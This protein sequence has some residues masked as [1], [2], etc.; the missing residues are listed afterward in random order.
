M[1]NKLTNIMCR[2]QHLTVII[3]LF[4]L[5]LA[6]FADVL[7][8]SKEIVLSKDGTDIY[9]QF[10]YWRS[11]GF[12]ELRKGNLALWNPYIFSGMPFLGGFQSAL[13]YPLN[14]LYLILPIIKAINYSIA[15][16]IFLAGVFMYLWTNHRKL[17]PFA[18]FISSVILMF[19][20][21]H[22]MHI[23]PGHL[24]NLCTMIWI[25]LLFLAIDGLYEKPSLG[26]IL[27][28]IFSITMQI[29]AG[30]PQYVY[31]TAI[32]AAIYSGLRIFKAKQKKFILL[33]LITM[34]LGA[35]ALSAVQLFTGI[36][37]ANESI[38]STGLSAQVSSMFSFP[39]ENLITFI[40]PYFFGNMKSVPYWGRWY[41]WEIIIFIS[42]T[43]FVLAIIG[44]IYGKKSI[45]CYSISMVLILFLF[46]FG[47]YTPLY[48][49]F[50]LII[51][52][53]NKFRGISKFIFHIS[54]FT[55]MLA[56]IGLDYL[57]K[58]K[59]VP[60]KIFITT[61]IVAIILCFAALLTT[62]SIR[63]TSPILWKNVTN[64]VANTH[65]SYRA[66]ETYQDLDFIK[67][68]GLLASKSLLISAA[69]FSL[70][71]LFLFLRKFSIK[72]IY[73]IG[74]LA[75]IELFIFGRSSLT[76]F[77]MNQ[78]RIPVMEKLAKE[79]PGD[80]RISYL[81]FPNF[82]MSLKMRNIWGH[83][84]GVLKRYAEFIAYTQDQNP[85]E[86][87]P[88]VD[89]T[90]MHPVY[91]MLRCRYFFFRKG[92]GLYLFESIETMKH[93][94]LIQDWLVIQERNKILATMA[95]P[96]F[97]PAETVILESQPDYQPIKAK[98][99]GTVKILDSSTDHLTIDANLLNPA[100]LLIT[101][102][103]SKGWH[104]KALVGSIQ[105]EYKIMPANYTL[106]AIP[107]M[108]GN[109]HIRV[110]YLPLAF[111]IGK[112]ISIVSL[113]VYLGLL[114]GFC[115]NLYKKKLIKK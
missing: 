96:K 87:S 36:E 1:K 60:R 77:N 94:E 31:Y 15:L 99:K 97:N 98:E 70:L 58:N 21:A 26:W 91:K 72:S 16:H 38:R 84:P 95:N 35:F 25:P 93:L 92:K 53:F 115:R 6:M 52:G 5:T 7:F 10:I 113:I 22:F 80:Y 66:F 106:M 24:P 2:Y 67:K 110:E 101:D 62:F 12:D 47:A 29:L 104:A 56:G 28:G 112:W 18:S 14:F 107:L 61:L 71:S 76:T 102:T 64:L 49:I 55:I 74:L 82:P 41:L 50:V 57:I 90:I 42:V 4:C 3:I 37:A 45:R 9:S 46:A 114:G 78:L 48:K 63:A 44:S 103:Y 19:C 32:A 89:I 79:N 100:I 111:R 69:T 54:L 13:L 73:A 85:D 20:G 109:H 75:I 65:Q 17:H 33:G 40:A 59:N 39:P 105:K 30:H 27:L 108:K 81:K 23:Y 8:T 11:F 86:A 88:Y 51:P 34:S 68:S 43:G 83:D